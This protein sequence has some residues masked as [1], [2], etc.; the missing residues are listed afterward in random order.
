LA[1]GQQVIIK[2]IGG[3]YEISLPASLPDALDAVIAV[4]YDK[5][6]DKVK[7]I[8]TSFQQIEKGNPQTL[9]LK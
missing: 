5:S 2:Q 1:N 4:Q 7:I 3:N 8:K 9:D 6:L